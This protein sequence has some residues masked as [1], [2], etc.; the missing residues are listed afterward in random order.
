MAETKAV[1]RHTPFSRNSHEQ[2]L[3][4]ASAASA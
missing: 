4:P 3:L 1:S 2:R